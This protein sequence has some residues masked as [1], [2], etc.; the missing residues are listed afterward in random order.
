M[1][2]PWWRH[3]FDTTYLRLHGHRFGEAGNR[4]E[5]AAMLDMLGLPLGARVLDLPCG[6]GRHT[7]LLAEAGQDVFGTDLSHV[8]LA[9]AADQGHARGLTPRFAAADMRELP[10]RNGSFDAVV[11]LYSSL[12]LFLDD[13]EDVRAMAEARR[14]LR[15]GGRF[16]LETMHRDDVVTSFAA[17]DAWELPDGTRVSVRR[18]F[19]PVR[20]VSYESL[21]WRRKRSTGRKRS[22]FRVRTATELDGMLRAA[23]LRPA[24]WFGGWD[25][26]PFRQRSDRLIVLAQRD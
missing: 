20:G 25:G 19:D 18:R 26:S 24:L 4:R 2:E 12:G 5:V 6:W 22:A 14:V 8:F 17:R 9:Q 11:N 1:K 3:H 23:G 10:F 21:R 7:N 16:L 15:P 13:A